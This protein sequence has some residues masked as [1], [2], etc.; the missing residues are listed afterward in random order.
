MKNS[1]T[2]PWREG[3]LAANTFSTNVKNALDKA[4][5]DAKAAAAA[6]SAANKTIVPS[7]VGSGNNSGGFGTKDT[8][9]KTALGSGSKETPK[10]MH[11]VS[12]LRGGATYYT[13]HE[14]KSTANK[15]KTV[16][17]KQYLWV[18]TMQCYFLLSNG[19]HVKDVG[20]KGRNF[21]YYFPAD[22]KYY[23]YYAKGTTGTKK[24]QWAI[25]DEPWLGDELT[26][27]AT[28]DGTL[29][30]M[31]AGSTVVPADLTK[32]LISLGEVG[33]DGLMN[34]PKV[35]SGI[36]LINN[37]VNKPELKI[38]VEN[39]LRCDNVSQDTLPE[40]KK[41]VNEQMN[42]LIK[43]LNYGLRKVGAN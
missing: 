6:I 16:D 34:M 27:Y 30:Y 22:T 41:F 8:G 9:G 1:L 15:V 7:Y 14:G 43:Q 19:T 37:V 11:V 17:G 10:Q 18:D 36:S 33:L 21:G 42:S 29:S 31:R 39:F 26:M 2:T 3:S 28:K 32:E 23:K 4:V 40:L 24:D 38:D 20:L 12:A 13:T 35:D 25:T 5:T